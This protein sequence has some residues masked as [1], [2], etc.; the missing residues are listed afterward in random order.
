MK[1]RRLVY[2]YMS[3]GYLRERVESNHEKLK[4]VKDSNKRMNIV[5]EN[6]D[7]LYALIYKQR[8]NES[9]LSMIRKDLT[10]VINKNKV[11]ES[12]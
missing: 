11:E 9:F 12:N 8:H 6:F 4:T 7:V 10:E 1:L 5:D 2:R 3:I